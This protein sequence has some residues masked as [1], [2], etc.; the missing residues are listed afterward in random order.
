VAAKLIV[1]AGELDQYYTFITPEAYDALKD[2]MEF[3]SSYDEQ[4]TGTSWLMRDI[5]Q[6][7]NINYYKSYGNG[8]VLWQIY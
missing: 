1:Y 5:W 7:K 6:T 4:V 3:R 8:Q 2:W